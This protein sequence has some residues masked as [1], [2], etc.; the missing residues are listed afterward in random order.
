MPCA[1]YIASVFPMKATMI[2][3]RIRVAL[4]SVA[5]IIPMGYLSP[6]LCFNRIVQEPDEPNLC[7]TDMNSALRAQYIIV[8]FVIVYFVPLVVI[9]I[10]N[11]R[12][13]KSLRETNPAIQQNNHIIQNQRT[14]KI[15]NFINVLFLSLGL[16]IKCSY[17][18]QN[19]Y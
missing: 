16:R 13:I 11:V 17:L 15:L 2:S 19:S 9:V 5:W 3:G 4:I 6:F 18:P 14:M 10:L 1:D 12:I 8:G 7:A